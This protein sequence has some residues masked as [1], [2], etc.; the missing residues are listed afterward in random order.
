MKILFDYWEDSADNA[1]NLA[2][3]IHRV[4]DMIAEG[5][6][7]GELVAGDGR[8]WWSIQEDAE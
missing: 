3:E 8:G 7:S 1:E 2:D 4:A 5:F 6:T